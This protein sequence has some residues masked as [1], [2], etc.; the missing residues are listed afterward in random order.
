M[1]NDLNDYINKLRKKIT[2]PQFR[3]K[4]ISKSK[5]TQSFY[6]DILN[7]LDK[8]SDIITILEIKKQNLIPKI[9]EFGKD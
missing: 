1:R 4:I 5:K 7:K 3:E 8:N 2:S 6:D 9:E